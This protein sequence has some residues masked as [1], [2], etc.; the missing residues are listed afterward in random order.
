MPDTVFEV[1]RDDTDLEQWVQAYCNAHIW[2]W[3]DTPTPSS[4]RDSER[5]EFFLGCLRAWNQDGVLVRFSIKNATGRIGLVVGLLEENSLVFHATTF[6][7]EYS[8]YSPGKA[9]IYYIASWMMEQKMRILDF[10]DGNEAYKYEVADQERVLNRIFVCGKTQFNF[11][12][13]TKLIQFVKEHP[14]MYNW[15]QNELKP[16]TAKAKAML[17]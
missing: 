5:Q 11:I 8:K 17:N 6:D 10:G 15:Y 1:F 7:P 16:W 2:R 9:L 13:R 12:A 14:N 3:A 4:F